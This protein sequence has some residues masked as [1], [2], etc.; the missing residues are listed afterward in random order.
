MLAGDSFAQT[1]LL[2]AFPVELMTSVW[3]PP[4]PPDSGDLP[5][6]PP[7]RGLSTRKDGDRRVSPACCHI[8]GTGSP[9]CPVLGVGKVGPQDGPGVWGRPGLHL[10]EQPL[11]APGP[12][13]GVG[14]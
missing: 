4:G 6:P 2:T 9:Q 12:P 13:R 14:K 3:Q 7:K 10:S 8:P 1:P 5:S 11:S